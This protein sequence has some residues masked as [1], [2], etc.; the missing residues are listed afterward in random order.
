[1]KRVDKSSN[2][3]IEQRSEKT[4]RS[5]VLMGRGKW[6]ERATRDREGVK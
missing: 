4:G 5:T 1:M 2:E 6:T 3:W